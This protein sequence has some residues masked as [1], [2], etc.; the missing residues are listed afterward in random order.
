[1]VNMA[2]IDKNLVVQTSIEKDDIKFYS[3]EKDPFKVYGIF[4]EGGKYRRIPESVAKAINDNV[5]V[6]HSNTAGGRVRF[7][8]DSDYVAISAKMDGLTKMARFAHTGSMGFDLYDDDNHTKV[9][10]PPLWMEDGFESIAEFGAE[11]EKKVREITINFPLYSNVKELYIG[12]QQDAV[13]EQPTPYKNE[14]PVVYYGSSITQGGFASKPGMS[15]QAIVSRKLNLDFINLGFSGNAKAE[16]EIVDYIKKLDMSL[17]VMDY[18]HNAPTV[19][20]LKNTHE[21]MFKA[22]RNENP[23]LPII[24]MSRPKCHLTAEEQQRLE[25]IK[26]TFNNALA[27]GDKN[28]Y[29]ITGKELTKIS[30]YEGTIDNTHPSDLGFFSMAQAVADVIEK[31]IAFK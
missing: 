7:R 22:I 2:K 9:F 24:M 27:A 26:T 23:K 20:H 13:V 29:L 3:V 25:I 21:K 30:G 12:L 10:I 1:M 19:E 15:Y 11:A 8:T 14:K 5:V 28:V 4:K 18:D 16:D 31:N 6:L 17:F